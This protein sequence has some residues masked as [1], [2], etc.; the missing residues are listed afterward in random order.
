MREGFWLL[1]RLQRAAGI[2]MAHCVQ[3]VI[4]GKAAGGFHAL[5]WFG[6]HQPALLQ[7]RQGGDLFPDTLHQ[8]GAAPDAKRNVGPQQKA[9]FTQLLL[10]KNAA[11][12]DG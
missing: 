7:R 11:P 9:D 8:G 5:I 2:R 12:P 3:R 6:N 10:R 1:Q 4:G